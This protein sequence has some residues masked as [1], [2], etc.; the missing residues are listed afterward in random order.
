MSSRTSQASK[1]LVWLVQ[2]VHSNKTQPWVAKCQKMLVNNTKVVVEVTRALL[3]AN[4]VLMRRRHYGTL[5]G[6]DF[7]A[8]GPSEVSSVWAT[9]PYAALT[10]FAS[11]NSINY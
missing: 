8:C 1:N 4:R 5:C 6:L 2:E 9:L 10:R 11:S 7:I 3:G